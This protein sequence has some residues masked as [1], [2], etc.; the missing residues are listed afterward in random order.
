[1]NAAQFERLPLLLDAAQVRAVTGWSKETLRY[2]VRRGLLSRVAVGRA[3]GKYRKADLAA[4]CGVHP[5]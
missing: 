5:A 3:R 2:R 1:M 4:L